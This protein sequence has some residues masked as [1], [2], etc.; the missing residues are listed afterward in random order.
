MAKVKKNELDSVE[1]FAAMVVESAAIERQRLEAERRESLERYRQIVGRLAESEPGDR[2]A[3]LLEAAAIIGRPLG[4][5]VAADLR[6]LDAIR[7]E[8]RLIEQHGDLNQYQ[9][10]LRQEQGTFAEEQAALAQRH[11]MEQ[12]ALRQRHLEH[13]RYSV[14]VGGVVDAASRARS[15]V[16]HLQ[17]EVEA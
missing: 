8:A 6:H 4:H 10:Q 12:T 1:D 15:A 7:D 3:R 5:D 9:Q 11:H 13:G 2:S 17:A 14:R 16:G